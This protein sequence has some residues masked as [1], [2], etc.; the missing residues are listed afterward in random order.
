MKV[1]ALAGINSRNYGYQNVKSQFRESVTSTQPQQNRISNVYYTH[2]SFMGAKEA[3]LLNGKLCERLCTG[4]KEATAKRPNLGLFEYLTEGYAP[5]LHT[6]SDM[7]RRLINEDFLFEIT[8]NKELSKSFIEEITHDPLKADEN[9]A[10][11]LGLF[12]N[13]INAFKAWYYH[14]DGYQRAYERYF[15]QEIFENDKVSVEDMVKISPNLMIETLKLKSL[16]TT[17]SQDF[18]I[19]KLP[20]EIGTTEDF[21]VLTQAIRDSQLVKEFVEF[22]DFM[23]DLDAFSAKYPEAKKNAVNPARFAKDFLKAKISEYRKAETEAEKAALEKQV[24]FLRLMQPTTV[25]VNGKKYTYSPILRPYSTKLLF[26]LDPEGAKNRYFVTMEMFNPTEKTCKNAAD[27]E[28]SAMRPDSPYLNAVVDYYLRS[29]GCENVP[30]MIYYD[31]GANAVIR[32]FINGTHTKPAGR[33]DKL[34]VVF[35]NTALK[36]ELKPLADRGIFITDCFFENFMKEESTGKILIVDNGHAKYSNALRP[37]VKMIHM[38]FA[39]L[40]GRD[41]VSLDA[42]LQRAKENK[43]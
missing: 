30:E 6:F 1:N 8:K 3:R 31:Y 38:G 17:G 32:P 19:G 18:T 25:E 34:G 9:L 29:N 7:E 16:R 2:P 36:K 35:E 14:Q 24:P 12:N 27:K 15:K 10:K 4:Y 33:T 22:R 41:F 11:L 21:R 26:A 5:Q 13:N 40:Y 28:N 43:V 39:D 42:S 23:E 20:E 37:G